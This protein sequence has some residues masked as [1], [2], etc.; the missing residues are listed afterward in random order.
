MSTCSQMSQIHRKKSSESILRIT[1]EVQKFNKYK[2]VKKALIFIFNEE[3]SI[4]FHDM[5]VNQPG[6]LHPWFIKTS[7]K[8]PYSK[9][10]RKRI[11]GK[12][13]VLT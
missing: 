12:A 9:V 1:K 4:N 13:S 2:N 11:A 10:W 6:S 5:I 3:S 7:R 8:I